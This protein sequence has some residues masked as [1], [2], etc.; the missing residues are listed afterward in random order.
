MIM[1]RPNSSYKITIFDDFMT[2][3]GGEA[4]TVQGTGQLNT[5]DPNLLET[6]MRL[7]CPTSGNVL[8]Y[9]AGIR[10]HANT[11]MLSS[12][13]ED[14][15]LVIWHRFGEPAQPP[16]ELNLRVNYGHDWVESFYEDGHTAWVTVTESDGFTVKATASLVTEAKD[17]W[18]GNT[19]FQTWPE[20]WFPS[21]PDILPGDWVYGWMDN[22]ASAKVQ[23]GEINGVIDPDTDS[24][25]GTIGASWFSSLLDVECFPWGAPSPQPGMKY[26]TAL[27]DGID[28]YTCSWVG[29]WD[30]Q[31]NQEVGVGYFGPDGNWV[32]NAFMARNPYVRAFPKDDKTFGFEWPL[33]E[34][35]HLAID[36]PGTE[37][38]PDYEQDQ[39]SIKTPWNP[40]S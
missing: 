12:G 19:G 2:Y 11:N 31:S 10:Y 20:V 36:D 17:F 33:G 9:Q 37:P 38:Y 35:I 7:E 14:G 4:G 3:C 25:V 23:I 22:G 29:E 1:L 24:I 5:E 32:A 34:L 18:G 16:P 28:T 27:P 26:D 21:M 8:E 13:W 30:I 39:Q 40:N 15:H 6:S